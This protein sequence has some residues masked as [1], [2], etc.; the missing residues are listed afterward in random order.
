MPK[1]KSRPA[2]AAPAQKRLSAERRDKANSAIGATYTAMAETWALALAAAGVLVTLAWLPL[3]WSATLRGVWILAR[4]D[5]RSAVGA[6]LRGVADSL[7]APVRSAATVLAWLLAAFLVT[8]VAELLAQWTRP[9]SGV[10]GLTL[11]LL[12][13]L[14]RAFCWVA[15]LGSFGPERTESA[16]EPRAGAT[17]T[18]S[19]PAATATA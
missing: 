8:A 5:R 18:A 2:A 15:L 16:A 4:P 14:G 17:V 9:L 13:G 6:W 1:D 12:G 19:G 7:H 10:L 11:S 3:A